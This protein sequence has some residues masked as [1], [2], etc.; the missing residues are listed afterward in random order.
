METKQFKYAKTEQGVVLTTQFIPT[1]TELCLK[2]GGQWDRANNV[3]VFADEKKGLE[4][5]DQCYGLS[6]E[7]V[8]VEVTGKHWHDD[9]I[10]N[11]GGYV[12]ARRQFYNYKVEIGPGVVMKKGSLPDN[13]G[14]ATHPMVNPSSDTVF[15]IEMC[16]DFAERAG[17]I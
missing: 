6:E 3:W 7:L 16:S 12:L 9:K 13:G 11:L 5:I 10:I 1:I 17:L 8:T 4:I 2:S 15:E 14:F